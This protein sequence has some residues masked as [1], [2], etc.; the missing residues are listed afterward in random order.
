MHVVHMHV[1]TIPIRIIV[2]GPVGTVLRRLGMAGAKV[3]VTYVRCKWEVAPEAG[4][5]LTEK[6]VSLVMQCGARKVRSKLKDGTV[7]C[8]CDGRSTADGECCPKSWEGAVEALD[9]IQHVVI[10][11]KGE[12]TGIDK[13]FYGV[14]LP[15]RQAARQRG[16]MTA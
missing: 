10:Y 16:H 15:E 12:H 8:Y 11:E 6:V 2:I 14:P 13:T 9:G 1:A 4:F 7:Y 5:D 3:R